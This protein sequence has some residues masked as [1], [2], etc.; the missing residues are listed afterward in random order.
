MSFALAAMEVEEQESAQ[1][2]FEY[3]T[4]DQLLAYGGL[5]DGLKLHHLKL[6]ND[7]PSMIYG[8]FEIKHAYNMS[9]ASHDISAR[10]KRGNILALD[11]LY[12][13]SEGLLPESFAEMSRSESS[14][15]DLSLA[16]DDVVSSPKESEGHARLEDD[17]QIADEKDLSAEQIS[18]L[19]RFAEEG[20]L[21]DGSDG[22]AC[23]EDQVCVERE[24][25]EGSVSSG[26]VGE[27][28]GS[29][30]SSVDLSG[31]F[32][33]VNP[34][35][36]DSLINGGSQEVAVNDPE[37]DKEPFDDLLFNQTDIP[38]PPQSKPTVRHKKIIFGTLS[39]N[40]NIGLFDTVNSSGTEAMKFELEVIPLRHFSFLDIV[41]SA[42]D[43]EDL[44]LREEGRIYMKYQ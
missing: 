11:G 34:L 35:A 36:V 6:L 29:V 43:N 17:Q 22:P 44:R 31:V 5:P 1:R 16:E 25:G 41:Q 13:L 42:Q 23:E 37:M 33:Q 26:E 24:E 7:S 40:S 20:G 8:Q 9:S 18:E 14:P 27:I 19:E 3:F 21:D 4:P 39:Q 32:Q 10:L 28:E 2:A 15:K 30:D 12:M 38:T